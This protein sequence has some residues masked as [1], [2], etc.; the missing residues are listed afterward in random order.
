MEPPAPQGF[1]LEIWHVVLGFMGFALTWAWNFVTGNIR[2]LRD[3]TVTKEDFKAYAEASQKQ[4]DELREA[5]IKLYGGQ[6]ALKTE[7]HA[8]ETRIITAV[9]EV[10]R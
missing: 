5:V 9:H 2:Q 3:T 6:D 4:R 8:I 1:V 10:K 7:M